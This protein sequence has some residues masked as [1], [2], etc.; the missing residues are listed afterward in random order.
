[1]NDEQPIDV[2]EQEVSH[3]PQEVQEPTQEAQV[4]ESNRIGTG[5]KCV[6]SSNTMSKD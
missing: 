1:M 4:Q 3:Q 2:L 5:E 6:K